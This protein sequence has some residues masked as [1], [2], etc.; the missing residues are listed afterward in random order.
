MAP[1]TA[2][3]VALPCGAAHRQQRRQHVAQQVLRVVAVR[4]ARLQPRVGDVLWAARDRRGGS[5][6]CYQMERYQMEDFNG[7]LVEADIP[8]EFRNIS[9]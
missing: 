9:A 1:S 4:E 5:A 2:P 3:L 7:P 6:G 8:Y